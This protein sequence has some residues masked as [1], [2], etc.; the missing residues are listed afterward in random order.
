[1]RYKLVITYDHYR[2]SSRRFRDE[3]NCPFIIAF[4]ENYPEK[5]GKSVGVRHAYDNGY[6]II[7]Q[8]L[9]PFNEWEYTKL[10]WL[11]RFGWRFET[12][13]VLN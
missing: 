6:G 12:F 1:M 8:I 10:K 13:I 9:K 7:A 2:K 4:K 11:G 3:R 5:G